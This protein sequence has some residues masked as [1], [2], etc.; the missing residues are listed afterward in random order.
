MDATWTIVF[1]G[2]GGT[3]WCATPYLSAL[4]RRFR[5]HQVVLIDPDV[6]TEANL[7]RQW[8]NYPQMVGSPKV[9]I[10]AEAL[11]T[12][13]ENVRLIRRQSKFIKETGLS[14]VRTFDDGSLL[15]FV[16]CTDNN[17]SRMAVHDVAR[18][19]GADSIVCGC[20]GGGGQAYYG[21][22]L[23]TY[24]WFTRHPDVAEP[25]GAPRVEIGC[26][27]Q[28]TYANALTGQLLC[29]AIEEYN[30]IQVSRD[31][32]PAIKEFWWEVNRGGRFRAWE[33]VVKAAE[34]PSEIVHMLEA[35][36][37]PTSL[38]EQESDAPIVVTAEMLA[39]AS[40]LPTVVREALRDPQ[41]E[42]YLDDDDLDELFEDEEN[43][44]TD[45]EAEDE[46]AEDEDDEEVAQ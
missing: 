3:F 11:F 1:V 14:L 46:E 22:R 39:A 2:C 29:L 6:L 26:G 23:L 13:D 37:E 19:L 36:S 15:L 35:P 20:D 27:G 33:T 45:E 34:V 8:C 44:V 42:D 41:E 21:S 5:F 40:P 25:G 43:D 10:A 17:E 16:V 12:G 7:E 9:D 24:D 4:I 31:Y 38:V 32:M 30:K 18:Q 28:T